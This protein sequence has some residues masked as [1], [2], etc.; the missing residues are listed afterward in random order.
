MTKI[1]RN[2]GYLGIAARY[3]HQKSRKVQGNR[4]ASYW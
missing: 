1:R 2:S 4:A 3:S